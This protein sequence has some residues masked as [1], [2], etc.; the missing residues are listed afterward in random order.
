MIKTLTLALV[1]SFVPKNFLRASKIVQKSTKKALG[2]F[3]KCS[4]S[5]ILIEIIMVPQNLSVAFHAGNRGSNPLG[6]ASKQQDA[7]LENI[8]EKGTVNRRAL[9]CLEQRRAGVQDIPLFKGG[10]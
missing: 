1:P 8:Y 5:L 6:D 4:L 10:Q 3:V 7:S 2:L 9:F